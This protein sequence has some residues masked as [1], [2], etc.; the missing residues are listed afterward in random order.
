[1]YDVHGDVLWGRT[2]RR[3]RHQ[4][5]LHFL[6]LVRRRYPLRLRL[7]IVLDNASAHCHREVKKWAKE[8]NAHLVFTPTNAS[9]LNRIECHFTPLK[10]FALDGAY[11]PNHRAQAWAIQRYM[12]ERNR[13]AR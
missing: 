2:Y 4:E 3:K 5:V 11:F 9:W 13:A 10:R 7:Y 8:N 6:R 12:K 1:M